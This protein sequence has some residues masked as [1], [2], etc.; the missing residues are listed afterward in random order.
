MN[1][2]KEQPKHGKGDNSRKM[3]QPSKS[4]SG[5]DSRMAPGK[6]GQQTERGAKPAPQNPGRDRNRQNDNGE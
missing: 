2:H 3:S 1:T 4:N 6:S 5:S